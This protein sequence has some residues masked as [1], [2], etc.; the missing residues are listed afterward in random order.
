MLKYSFVHTEI[1]WMDTTGNFS[2]YWIHVFKEIIDWN[3][4]MFLKRI[5]ICPFVK[6]NVSSR[7]SQILTICMDIGGVYAPTTHPFLY[8]HYANSY[9]IIYWLVEILDSNQWQRVD[10]SIKLV[11]DGGIL[12][13]VNIWNCD[14]VCLTVLLITESYYNKRY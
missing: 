1:V 4:V 2:Y 11:W 8:E 3:V 6:K 10:Q 5:Y 14:I 7:L 12:W 9:W 13:M